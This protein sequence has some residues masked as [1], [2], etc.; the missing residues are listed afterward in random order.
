MSAVSSPFRLIK[1]QS[2]VRQ[3]KKKKKKKKEK[4]RKEKEKEKKNIEEAKRDSMEY[5]LVFSV[6]YFIQCR[7]PEVSLLKGCCFDL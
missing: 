5:L 2:P 4:K 6:I 3:K 7:K 1:K